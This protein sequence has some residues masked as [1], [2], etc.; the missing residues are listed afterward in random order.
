MC[1]LFDST[2]TFKFFPLQYMIL[3]FAQDS[4]FN[5]SS[6]EFSHFLKYQ[7]V[8]E[9]IVNTFLTWVHVLW[10]LHLGVAQLFDFTFIEEPIAFHW[11]TEMMW[12]VCKWIKPKSVSTEFSMYFITQQCERFEQICT[13]KFLQKGWVYECVC[14]FKPPRSGK[15]KNLMDRLWSNSL[16]VG[17]AGLA[18]QSIV[19]LSFHSHLLSLVLS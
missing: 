6:Q 7:K 9:N 2:T 3:S 12:L 13:S 11:L 18:N 10:I 19:H 14:I 16:H 8:S 5:V 17:V 4:I 15:V 1:H